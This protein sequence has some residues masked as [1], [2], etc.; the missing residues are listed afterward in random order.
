VSTQAGRWYVGD[1]GECPFQTGIAR[2]AWGEVPTPEQREAIQVLTLRPSPSQALPAVLPSWIAELPH[3]TELGLPILHLEQL[4]PEQLPARLDTLVF[5]AFARWVAPDGSG[6]PRWPSSLKLPNLRTLAIAGT[7]TGI[8]EGLCPELA[9]A[10]ASVAATVDKKGE[11]L[12]Q[13]GGFTEL[14]ELDLQH[15]GNLDVFETLDGDIEVLRL[16]GGG[17]RFPF[18]AISRWRS[19][20]SLD[21]YGM[22]G[23]IDCSVLTELPRL[24]ELRMNYCTQLVDVEAL[25]E[26]PELRAVAIAACG[27]PFKDPALRRAFAEHGFERLDIDR[28]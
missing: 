26:C 23:A 19:I 9:P 1:K 3:C 13:L 28:A 18:D 24:S 20:T 15:V 8:P 2:V 5:E 7:M 14:R 17:R 27:R 12:D 11:L 6:V 21:L 10:L 22:Q 4:R 25:L 16:R